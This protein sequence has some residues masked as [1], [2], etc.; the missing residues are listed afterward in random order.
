MDDVTVWGRRLSK[1]L[2]EKCIFI[3]NF[4]KCHKMTSIWCNL[5]L[6]FKSIEMITVIL[7]LPNEKWCVAS[8]L[9][10]KWKVW[11]L[12]KL[13]IEISIQDVGVG[14]KCNK[15][16]LQ[17]KVSNPLCKKEWSKSKIMQNPMVTINI[18]VN[19]FFRGLPFS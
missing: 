14:R 7:Q 9:N 16:R 11:N 17:G 8:F 10:T 1:S 19:N 12:V 4:L 2:F 13:I 3:I 18:C 15:R 6:E 5:R